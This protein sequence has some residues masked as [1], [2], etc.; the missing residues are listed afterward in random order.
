MGIIE[1]NI[2][3]NYMKK[4]LKKIE[5]ICSNFFDKMSKNN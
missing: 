2:G 3:K 4:R 5:N 1:I